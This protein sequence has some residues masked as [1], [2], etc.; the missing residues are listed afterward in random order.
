IQLLSFSP[1]AVLLKQGRQPAGLYFVVDGAFTV[2]STG[3]EPHGS[4]GRPEEAAVWDPLRQYAKTN[5][6]ERHISFLDKPLAR[7]EVDPADEKRDVLGTAAAGA[8]L[9][10]VPAMTGYPSFAT[11]RAAVPSIVARFPLSACQKLLSSHPR[12]LAWLSGRLL[13]R[14]PPLSLHVDLAMEWL[15]PRASQV[16]VRQGDLPGRVFV[17]LQGRLRSIREQEPGERKVSFEILGEHA[18]GESIGE[19]EV[20]MDRPFPATVHAIRDSE[21]AAVPATLFSALARNNP[22][23]MV[24]LGRVIAGGATKA[25]DQGAETDPSL[26]SVPDRGMLGGANLK[27]V[28]IIPVNSLVPV[29]EFAERLRDALQIEGA[30]AAVL[31]TAAVLSVLGKHAFTRLGKLKLM[32]WLAEQEET[33]RLVLYVADGQPRAPWTQRCIRQADAVLVVGLGDEEPAGLEDRPRPEGDFEEL[34]KLTTARKDLVLLHNERHVIQGS[35]AKWL[36]TR[37]WVNAHHHVSHDTPRGLMLMLTVFAQVQMHVPHRNSFSRNA[38]GSTIFDGANQIT[39]DFRRLARRMLAKTIGLVLGGGGA[40]GLAHVGMIKALE[41]AGIEFDMIGG[42]SQ[43]AFIGG[44]LAREGNSVAVIARS[45]SFASRMSSTVSYL[46]D[47]TYPGVAYFTGH[48]FNRTVWKTF[49]D[50]HI[51]DTWIP[52][53]CTAVN[54]TWSRLDI[55]RSGYLW[56][57]VRASMSLMGLVPPMNSNGDMLVDGGY[58]NNLPADVAR[59]LGAA[60]IIA[61][62]VGGVDDTSPVSFGDHISGWT[63]LWDRWNPFKDKRYQRIP[64]MTEL[65]SR[66]AYV[67]QVQQLEE[68]KRM[69]GVFYL[70]PPTAKYG[71]LEFGKGEDIVALGYDFGRSIIKKWREDGTLASFGIVD[72]RPYPRHRRA[73]HGVPPTSSGSVVATPSGTRSSAA[74]LS[75]GST[76]P[77]AMEGT[78]TSE[79][80]RSATPTAD[81]GEGDEDGEARMGSSDSFS[82]SRRYSL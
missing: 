50:S 6:G 31:N 26:R 55:E 12:V 10:Y 23:I 80:G 24:Q 13:S 22:E 76:V 71:I 72:G 48:E 54:V 30:S 53:F 61:V 66:V 29:Q 60:K 14:L 62:D 4:Y 34:L 21:V 46:M 79:A 37:N 44:I 43:G 63:Y 39:A 1:S 52:F 3:R 35:T 67:S 49:S 33:S 56:R 47:V 65:Q 69:D 64:S 81:R 57:S 77:V 58:I 82:R 74:K 7:D 75:R 36:R 11:A 20:V 17:V 27:T 15:Q 32:N 5:Q 38:H 8:V 18:P 19:V 2:T 45:K 40:R 16:V 51:E 41:E 25:G 9:G 70:H 68:V 42:T 59:S 28:A 73:S 78:G